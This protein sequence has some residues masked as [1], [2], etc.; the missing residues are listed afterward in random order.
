MTIAH[1]A[2]DKKYSHFD[3]AST[4][5]QG[6]WEI[7]FINVTAFLVE[8]GYFIYRTS[9]TRWFT[10]RIID[11][12]V[13]IVGKKDLK[14]EIINHLIK[15]D[16]GRHIHQLFLK[17]IAKAVSDEFIETLPAKEVD[18]RRDRKDA[19]QIYYQ[20]CIVKIT[21]KAITTHP[22]TE[23]TG[24]IWESQIL[25]R[26]FVY[27]PGYQ[28]DF[29][30]FVFNVS[31]K[32]PARYST[33]CSAL[34]FM[35]SS[36]KNPA[37][38]PAIIFNDEVISDHPEGG[39]GKGLLIKATEQFLVTATEEGKTFSFD[40]NFVYQKINKD[41]RLHFFQDVQKNFDFERLFSVL[42]DGITIEKKGMESFYIKFKESPKVA[43]TT[44]YAIRGAGNSHERRRFEIEISQYYNK[45]FTPHDEFKSMFFDDWKTVQFNGFDNF[46]VECC[47]FFLTRGLVQQELVHLPEK[48]LVVDTSA[49]FKEFADELGD[50]KLISQIGKTEL[51]E[52][53]LTEYDSYRKHI[54]FTK[55]Y[56][57]KW[58][59]SYCSYKKIKV[60][61]EARDKSG[62]IRCYVFS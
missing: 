21:S 58:V 33:I 38:C 57:Q 2:A 23:L 24:Y 54:W 28:S 41:T 18:F 37:Y 45:G 4:N 11:N 30:T 3:L 17:S 34:G 16:S 42:T 19:I 29:R 6:K 25:Q 51:Y 56:F 20:N 35:L 47:Q 53:F 55:N 40:K 14:D 62:K 27:D 26:D 12:I 48:R 46:M 22:Y 49:D 44:N 31:N 8:R 5:G 50:L 43:I 7:D 10:I 60:N 61:T 39:T 36:Y 32:E 1:L 52:K 15:E 13:K 9:P 59:V